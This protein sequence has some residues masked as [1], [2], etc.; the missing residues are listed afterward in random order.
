MRIKDPI[1]PENC[2]WTVP[3]DGSLNH[4]QCTAE[5]WNPLV[6]A[7]IKVFKYFAFIKKR[8]TIIP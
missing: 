7:E 1:D 3:A 2:R 5:L 8:T 6:G 4:N